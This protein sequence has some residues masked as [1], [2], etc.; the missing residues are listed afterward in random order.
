MTTTADSGMTPLIG[1]KA[2]EDEVS[3]HTLYNLVFSN[4]CNSIRPQS[5]LASVLFSVSSL[6]S[7]D[8]Y[9]RWRVEHKPGSWPKVYLTVQGIAMLLFFG[10]FP[11]FAIHN[12]VSKKRE[13]LQVHRMHSTFFLSSLANKVC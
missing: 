12:F 4:K 13:S 10:V 1:S 11:S 8:T 2:I 6:I 5:L 9:L 3:E 7:F